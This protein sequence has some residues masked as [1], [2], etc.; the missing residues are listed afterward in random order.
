MALDLILGP[1]HAG[2][3]AELCDAYLD[4]LAAGRSA[5]LV[6][7]GAEARARA[8]RDLLARSPALLGADVVDFDELFERILRLTGDSRRVLR[9]GA[10]QALL[11]RTLPGS[12]ASLATRLQRL[13]SALL[14]PD[15]VRAAG[16]VELADRYAAWWRA[17]DAAH[18]VD[19]GRMRIEV[20]RALEADVAAWPAGE[21][22]FVQG[23]DDLSPAQ[24]A[25]IDRIAQRARVVLTLA[26]EA[27]R[28]PFRALAPMAARLAER[29]G[30]AGI[31]ELPSLDGGR[32]VDLV[33]LER[34]FGD[35][36]PDA[37]CAASTTG[38]VAFAEVE[39]ERGEAEVVVVEIAAAIRRGVPRERIAVIAPRGA[40]DRRRL[41]RQ[42]REAGIDAAGDEQRLVV[43]TAFGRALLALLSLAWADDPSDADR[44]AW[45]RSPWSDAPPHLVDRL[46]RGVRRAQE[47]LD[48]GIR[49]ADAIMRALAP[50]P[51]A[52]GGAGAVDEAIAAVRGMLARAHRRAT[53]APDSVALLDDV[54]QAQAILSELESLRDLDPAPSRDEVRA[55]IGQIAYAGRPGRADAIRVLDPRTARSVDV[56]VA[57]VVG[58][59]EQSF[60]VSAAA[61]REPLVDAPEQGDVARHLAY[62]ALTRPRERLLLVRRVADDDG[63]PLAPTAIWEDLLAAA[64]E[65]GIALRRRFSDAAFDLDDAPTV[66][67]RARAIAAIAAD[68]PALAR[69]L[70]GAAGV[71]GALR[72]ALGA[73]RPH[74]RLA[75]QRVLAAI[76]DREPVGIT[77]IDRFG[78]CS[79]VWFVERCLEPKS[80]DEPIDDRRRRGTIAHS[81][82]AR[83]YKEVPGTLSTTAIGPAEADAAAAEAVRI[84][85][86]EIGR[87]DP[88]A[89]GDRLRIDLMRWGLRRDIARLV[90]RL[91]L[92][93]APLVPTEFE[94]AFGGRNAQAG[95]KDGLDIGGVRVSG[96]I[97]RIDTDPMMTARAIVV[98]YKT[99]EVSSAAQMAER[100]E[101]QVPLY[102]LALREVLGREPVAGL[103]VSVRRGQARGLADADASDV[104]PPTLMRGDVLEHDAFE[105]ALETARGV[106]LERV[107]RMRAGDVRLDPQGGGDYCRRVCDYAGICRRAL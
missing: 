89:P 99:T 67:E 2:K 96:K 61:A 7:P 66:R 27:G 84:V 47:R 44:L 100:G 95:R 37:R 56:D 51:G 62:V 58:C 71:S 15:A 78:I 10:R 43:R 33:A 36:D 46:D 63:R 57:V 101:V 4:E 50:P 88:V 80:I 22:L 73:W 85:D 81:I 74:S 94:V 19:R 76:R 79:S 30:P 39:G 42:L 35:P 21:A 18:A 13:G 38:G 83:I 1:A 6:V 40:A 55:C 103:L 20:V 23:F 92:S 53:A 65:P 90:R 48:D 102:L 77:G 26:Y 16:D 3:V 105:N 29:A 54:A 52:R 106:A 5:L 14:D 60:G 93:G 11:Q 24:E 68:D 32:Q 34:R 98:D 64:G 9:G 31:R 25:V 69:Q 45:L 17:L 97:D 41:V 12:P 70:A 49:S 72:R 75:D 8:R 107:E 82:L 59:E 86:E 91:A 104:L 87:I 28:P